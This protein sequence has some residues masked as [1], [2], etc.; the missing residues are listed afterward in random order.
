VNIELTRAQK[1]E[2]LSYLRYY[3]RICLEDWWKQRKC[4]HNWS[5]DRE[6]NLGPLE[7]ETEF[8]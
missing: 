8:V 1:K 2:G 7:Y 4:Q 3:F 6:S 5:S